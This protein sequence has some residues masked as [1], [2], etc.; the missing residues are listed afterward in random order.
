MK[1]WIICFMLML[2]LF[3][4]PIANAIKLKDVPESRTIEITEITITTAME[5][6]KTLDKL[7]ETDG[8]IR[9]VL[10][11]PGGQILAGLMIIDAMDRCHNDIQTYANGAT[12]SMGVYILS[13]GTVGKRVINKHGQVLMHNARVQYMFRYM[14]VE[15]LQDDIDMIEKYQDKLNKI[16]SE[17]TGLSIADVKE[18]SDI[19]GITDA[20]STVELNIV[21]GI[22][23]GDE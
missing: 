12:Y 23:E 16:L 15:D 14:T 22:Y 13:R 2:L 4:V 21:D 8:D 20:E 9:I 7:D 5:I 3:A 11:T 1:K 18:L 6:T 10:T 17:S 19:N